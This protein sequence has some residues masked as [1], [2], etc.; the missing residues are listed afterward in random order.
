MCKN[1]IEI[2][3]DKNWLLDY[4]EPWDYTNTKRYKNYLAIVSRDERGEFVYHWC[5]ESRESDE[6]FNITDI[7]EGDILLAIRI[8]TSLADLQRGITRFLKRLMRNSFYMRIQHI[9]RHLW[10][11]SLMIRRMHSKICMLGISLL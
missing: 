7:K 1:I 3:C 4:L 10:D 6:Y 2:E 8:T 5:K 9:G 11:V